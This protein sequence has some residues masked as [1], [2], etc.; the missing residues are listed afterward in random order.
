MHNIPNLISVLRL[1][2]VPLTVWLIIS[3]AHGWA[4][5]AF[6]TAG[7]SDGVDGYL[8]RRF[9]WRTRLGAYLDPL[10]DKAL[11]VSVFV[12]LGFLKLIPAWLVI[13]VVSRDA[14]I[15]G[16]VLLSRLMDH[17][18]HVRPLMVSK[19]NTVAQILFA[20]S[21]LGAAA[22][23]K[24]VAVPVDYGSIPVAL[25]TALSGAAYLASWLRHMAEHPEGG[26]RP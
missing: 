5:L 19:V 4:F 7:V 25:L 8:A 26:Q 24:Q 18:V 12:T 20:V 16:A 3:E 2:L 9:D 1:L 23:G 10:A 13:I 6:M 21:V 22:F 17:P 14:L 11:L 15:V